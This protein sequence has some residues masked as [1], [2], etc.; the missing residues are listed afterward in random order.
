MDLQIS[1]ALKASFFGAV[2][3]MAI[4]RLRG[5]NALMQA[6]VGTIAAYYLGEP[7]AA[8]ANHYITISVKAVHFLVGFLAINLLGSLMNLGKQLQ[9]DPSQLLKFLTGKRDKE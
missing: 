3:S 8:I 6:A 1:E 2:V 9:K 7:L 4:R 5:W